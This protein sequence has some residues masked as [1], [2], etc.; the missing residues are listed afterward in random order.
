MKRRE[1]KRESESKQASERIFFPCSLPLLLQK[2]GLGQPRARRVELRLVFPHGW[3]S[4]QALE[5]L[6]DLL[7]ART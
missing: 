2:P 1:R 6:P 3:L 5:P 4:C 7:D